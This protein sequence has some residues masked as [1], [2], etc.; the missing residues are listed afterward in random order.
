MN[1]LFTFLFG[2][3]VFLGAC[4]IFIFKDSK[5]IIEMSISM[6]FSVLVFLIFIEL[7]P[8]ALEHFKYYYV[9]IYAFIG[10]LF[11]K[12]LDKFI[13]KH[14]HNEEGHSF[15][16]SLMSSIALIIHNIIE[17]MVLYQS[18]NN[19]FGMGLMMGFGIGLHNIP[20]GLIISSTL[21][22]A[23]FSK[24]KI[25]IYTFLLSLSTL[26]GGFIMYL[27]NNILLHIEGIMLSITLG[28][29]V[30]ITFFELLEHMQNQDKKNNIIGLLIG[31]I[32]F[33]LS[34]L[35]HF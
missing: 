14:N 34:M 11:L 33:L 16:I 19:D 18:L 21:T 26:F 4:L 22:E 10:L 29:I 28:M 23:K 1:L 25:A 20:M 12:I 7:L 2:L 9:L 24:K 17:G 15:H 3:T 32:L 13:P 30:Y 31:I 8:E 5:K 27:F 6:G 35:L